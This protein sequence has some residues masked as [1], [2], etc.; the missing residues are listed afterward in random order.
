MHDELNDIIRL[1]EGELFRQLRAI[2]QFERLLH[3]FYWQ[4]D[5]EWL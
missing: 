3:Q 2:Y 4:I 5:S 1:L